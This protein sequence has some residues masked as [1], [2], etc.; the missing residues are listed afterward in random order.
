MN[1]T[2][3]SLPP[4][5]LELSDGSSPTSVGDES[6]QLKPHIPL[7]DNFHDLPTS[8]ISKLLD[9]MD[10]LKGYLVTLIQ[11]ELEK[12]VNDLEGII[13]EIGGYIEKLGELQ[14]KKQQTQS[15]LDQ[16]QQLTK[17]WEDQQKQMHEALQ[18]FRAENIHSLLQRSVL[19]SQ[20]LSDSI[21][22]TFVSHV[23]QHDEQSI[24]AFIKTY[25]QER[26]LYYLRHEKLQRYQESRIGGLTS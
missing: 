6:Q 11:N 17:E 14:A 7:P 19:E 9:T 13:K 15:R 10:T 22:L 5:G 18:R 3:P 21:Q 4:K 16:I 2:P 1:N 20:K 24:Q 26:K 8:E 12:E 25:K 23:E